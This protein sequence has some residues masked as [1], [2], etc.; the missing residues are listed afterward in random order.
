MDY[1]LRQCLSKKGIKVFDYKCPLYM[2]HVF[3]KYCINQAVK[4]NF[5]KKLSQP[6]RPT[7]IDRNYISFVTPTVWN[8]MPSDLKSCTDINIFYI[9]LLY[10]YTLTLT[11]LYRFFEMDHNENK[12]NIKCFFCAIQ[13]TKFVF[14]FIINFFGYYCVGLT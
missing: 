10:F 7:I 4:R 5:S 9:T 1:R 2:K 8:K 12:G 11:F 6:L 13:S 3:G 14:T